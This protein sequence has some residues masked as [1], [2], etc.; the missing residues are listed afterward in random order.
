MKTPNSGFPTDNS[1]VGFSGLDLVSFDAMNPVADIRTVHHEAMKI[2]SLADKAKAEQDLDAAMSLYSEAFSKE[3]EFVLALLGTSANSLT[4]SVMIRSAATLG[5]LAGQ[6]RE[7]EKLVALG[8]S[9]NIPDQIAEEL[10]D[11]FENIKVSRHQDADSGV[12][13][14]SMF[15]KADPKAAPAHVF[16]ELLSAKGELLM[17]DE[18]KKRAVIKIV[19]H[20][21][22]TQITVPK[23]LADIVKIHWGAEVVAW[24]RKNKKLNILDRL[25][26]A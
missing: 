16:G 4:K 17:A 5:F 9:M 20:A 19:D 18:S 8:L 2:A 12:Q 6:L 24:Y 3:R 23:G 1:R 14:P 26:P 22:Q 21:T 10:R 15:G 25:E 13:L 11:L 7:A